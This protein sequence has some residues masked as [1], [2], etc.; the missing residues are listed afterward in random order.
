ME[1]MIIT[2]A[3]SIILLTVKNPAK[4]A[5]LKAVMLKLRNAINNVYAG[6]PDFSTGP[7]VSK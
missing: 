6:D 5:S 1:D 4:K 3:L 2:M 7:I